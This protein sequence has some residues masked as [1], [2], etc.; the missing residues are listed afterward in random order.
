M[1]LWV[2]PR[3]CPQISSQPSRL[4]LSVLRRWAVAA[5]N[6]RILRNAA[7]APRPG[8]P[9]SWQG[10]VAAATTRA[11]HPVGQ[12]RKLCPYQPKPR[13]QNNCC[14]Q[15]SI[16]SLCSVGCCNHL[17]TARVSAHLIASSQ[18]SRTLHDTSR[19]N[20]KQSSRQTVKAMLRTAVAC[21]QRPVDFPASNAFAKR[22]NRRSP[23]G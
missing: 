7:S 9:P 19:R 20:C 6:K 22:H 4:Q 16:P 10:F 14:D 15:G 3:I 17:S 12:R 1:S 5:T 11:A 18:T 21:R 8:K 23:N 2:V 13:F